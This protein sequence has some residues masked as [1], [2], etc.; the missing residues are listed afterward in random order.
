M[1][2]AKKHLRQ[3][4]Q[5]FCAILCSESAGT[6]KVRLL[7]G[8]LDVIFVLKLSIYEH[9]GSFRRDSRGPYRDGAKLGKPR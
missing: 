1:G 3:C 8:R 2:N 6:Y 4:D 5:I 9:L 7:V